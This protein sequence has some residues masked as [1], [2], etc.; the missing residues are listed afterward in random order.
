MVITRLNNGIRVVLEK[1]PFFRSVSVG[2]WIKAGSR[3]ESSQENGISHFIEHMLFKGTDTRNAC[4][5]AA[6]IDN[7]GGTLNAFTSKECTCYYVHVMDEHISIGIRL[8]ADMLKN[9]KYLPEEI[10]KEKGVVCE[11]ISMVDDTPDDLVHELASKG[12]YG[13]DPLGMTILGPK[14]NVC[15]FNADIIRRYLS[16]RY[17]TGN[18]VI[19]VAGNIDENKVL[20]L[21][22]N[23]F[24]DNITVAQE[25][26]DVTA[27]GNIKPE[28][29]M[30]CAKDNEQ[31]NMCLSFRG[32]GSD[33]MYFYPLTVF[34]CLFGGSMSSR[35]FQNIREQHGLT[36]SVFSY[37]TTYRDTGSFSIYAGMNPEQ[38]ER[39]MELISAEIRRALSTR[40]T[41]VELNNAREQIKGSLIL[42]TEGARPIMSRNGKMLL[43]KNRTE[44]LEEL[45]DNINSVTVQEVHDAVNSVFNNEYCCA[46]VGKEKWIPKDVSLN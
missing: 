34:N 31:M 14:E 17:T 1:V 42:G 45:I 46:F 26:P 41:Q 40:L 33:D 16:K 32:V 43:L 15:G 27:L 13:S 25:S 20:E 30:V 29:L 6:E 9:S 7:I 23:E 36:Y 21:L 18:I 5:I 39:V 22:G 38:T 12:L 19:S 44:S 3:Y 35:L 24:S 37:Q 28:K 8:L 2:V 11:E 4:Q 10:E